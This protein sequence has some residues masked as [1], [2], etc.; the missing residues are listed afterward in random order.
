MKRGERLTTDTVVGGRSLQH[1]T[2]ERYS[3]HPRIVL[4]GSKTTSKP[5]M[6]A[7]CVD[8]MLRSVQGLPPGTVGVGGFYNELVV[9]CA[10]TKF[11]NTGIDLANRD[12]LQPNK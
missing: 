11:P 2:P 3:A 4:W 12:Q 5:G 9:G 10:T 7:C 1:C 6:V 8:L